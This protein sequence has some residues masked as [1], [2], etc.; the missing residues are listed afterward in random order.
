MRTSLLVSATSAAIWFAGCSQP[1]DTLRTPVKLDELGITVRDVPRSFMLSDKTGGFFIGHIGRGA[2]RRRMSWTVF[3]DEVPSPVDLRAGSLLLSDAQLDSAVVRPDLVRR[4]YRNGMVETVTVLD[5]LPSPEGAAHAVLLDVDS[6]SEVDI[7]LGLGPSLQFAKGNSPGGAVARG[8]VKGHGT[9]TVTSGP[10]GAAIG[11][12]IGVQHTRRA[13]FLLLLAPREFPVGSLYRDADSLIARRTSRMERLLTTTYVR[14]SD[15]TLTRALCWMKLSVDAMLVEGAD[16]FAVA[17]VPW[18]GSISGRDNAQAITGIGF[19]TGNYSRLAAIIRS[20]ARWQDRSASSTTFGRIADRVD[21]GRASYDGADVG[22][23][24]AREMYEYVVNSDDTVLVKEMYPVVKRGIDGTMKY[25]VDRN[26]LLVHGDGETW[27][28]T[29]IPGTGKLSFVP[30]GNRA[31]EI[32]LL[33]YFQQLIGSY[34]ASYVGDSL[35]AGDWS[36]LA[37]Q[38][39]ASFDRYFVDTV[40]NA[41]YDHVLSNGKGAPELRPNPMFCLEI[42]GSEAVQQDMIKTLISRLVY[43]NG[44]GTLESTDPRFHAFVKEDGPGMFNGPVW[45]WLAGQLAYALSRYDRQDFSYEV[46]GSMVRMLEGRG[47]VGALPAMMDVVPKDGA[48]E[49]AGGGA[50]ASLNGMAEFLR[51]FYQDYLGLRIDVPSNLLSI[52]PKLPEHLTD[53]DFTVLFGRHPVNCRIEKRN[54]ISRIVLAAPEIPQ[55]VRVSF[56][57]ML[58]NGDAWRGSTSLLPNTTL[59]IAFSKNDML[60]YNGDRKAELPDARK[61]K[62]FS[63]RG[64]FTGFDFARPPSP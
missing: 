45:T 61:L 31:V 21:R 38:T 35:S 20:L 23:W 15:T 30:R 53:A 22:P 25:H 9:L 33:W 2:D 63:L 10:E 8:D 36:E 55:P 46:M 1:Q 57:W 41:V 50:E 13:R 24:F 17:G 52:Q 44:F 16:T 4:F 54:D 26:N 14:T 37:K 5:H 62:G 7:V 39:S 56:L 60:A 6:P 32:Q 59:T 34:M 42:L 29:R 12:G 3:G 19:A 64:S 48:A 58:D 51:A 28:S 49:P 18:D 11:D 43:P 47:M 40:H 27:M